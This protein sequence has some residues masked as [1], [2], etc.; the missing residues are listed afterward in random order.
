MEKSL[1]IL[2]W[3]TFHKYNISP[4]KKIVNRFFVKY[5]KLQTKSTILIKNGAKG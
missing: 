5:V 4:N 2:N 3:L 1:K